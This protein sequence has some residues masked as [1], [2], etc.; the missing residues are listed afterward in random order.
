ME[1][2]EDNKMEQAGNLHV[3]M[4]KDNV[5]E[6]LFNH[7]LSRNTTILLKLFHS[8]FVQKVEIQL[9]GILKVKNVPQLLELTGIKFLNVLL[10]LKES[11]IKFKWQ[12][13]LKNLFQLILMSHGLLLMT[14]IHQVLK[15]PSLKI[16]LNLYVP[17]IKDHKK[18]LLVNDYFISFIYYDIQ[19]KIYE[20]YSFILKKK[21]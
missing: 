6:I 2:L 3:N 21:V 19:H 9:T 4:E 5:K 14:N 8:L 18:L 10:Q 15:M 16:W 1:M 7:V 13:L 17:S 11:D 12:Q 20:F